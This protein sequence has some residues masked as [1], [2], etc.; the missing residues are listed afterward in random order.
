MEWYQ[1]LAWC[2]ERSSTADQQ[3]VCLNMEG[4]GGTDCPAF[5]SMLTDYVQVDGCIDLI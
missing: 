2:L 4:G 5:Q 3:I 1:A